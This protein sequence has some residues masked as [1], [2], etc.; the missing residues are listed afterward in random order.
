VKRPW[1]LCVNNSEAEISPYEAVRFA[2]K[3]S[4]QRAEQA[5]VILTHRNGV[6]MG[7]FV[8][9]QWLEV[10]VHLRWW[11]TSPGKPGWRRTCQPNARMHFDVSRKDLITESNGYLV[12]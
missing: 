9:L 4:R 8:A 12:A 10:F 6:I 2:W 7:A 5:E 3:V 1:L 11:K